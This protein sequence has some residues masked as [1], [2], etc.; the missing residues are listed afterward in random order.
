MEKRNDTWTLGGALIN[1][2]QDRTLEPAGLQGAGDAE[3]CF[4][5]SENGIAFAALVLAADV[6]QTGV[7]QP[8]YVALASFSQAPAG[9]PLWITMPADVK[10]GKLWNMV[11]STDELNIAFLYSP[12]NKSAG[13]RMYSAAVDSRMAVDVVRGMGAKFA[14]DSFD[15]MVSF[16]FISKKDTKSDIDSIIFVSEKRGREVLSR[17]KLQKGETPTVLWRAGGVAGFHV[18]GDSQNRILVSSSNFIDSRVW[19]IISSA[20][21]TLI[22]TVAPADDEHACIGLSP[23]MVTEAYI[24][25]DNGHLI[26]T[27]I[28]R[29]SDFDEFKRYPWLLLIHGGPVAS[30]SDCWGQPWNAAAIAQQGYVVVLPNIT[31]S[32]GYGLD[33]ARRIRGDWLGAPCRDLAQITAYLTQLPFLDAAKGLIAGGSYGGY[34]LSWMFSQPLIRQFCGAVWHSGIFSAQNFPLYKDSF[35]YDSPY[36]GATYSWQDPA[37]FAAADPARPE[38]LREWKHAPPTL[39]IHPEKD[40]RCPVTEGLAAFKTLQAQGV[41]SRFLTFSDECHGI[42]NPENIKVFLETVFD[43]MERCVSGELESKRRTTVY[44][45]DV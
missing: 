20:D 26:H 8:H 28:I 7:C 27:F 33:F 25:G 45:Q 35:W 37:A 43:W 11:F 36:G 21:G 30:W 2:I 34:M 17:L 32:T 9:P 14:N 19:Q 4:A 6:N 12:A 5:I 24:P 23:S 39:V 42:G 22:H 18:L 44:Q 31:G 15:P 38:L 3:G 13:T 10:H 41:P 29:P 16:E 40:Y 1:L